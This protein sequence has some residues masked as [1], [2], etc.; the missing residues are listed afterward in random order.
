M[1]GAREESELTGKGEEARMK[2]R[3][4]AELNELVRNYGPE[5]VAQAI[6]K[7]AAARA[8]GADYIAN[9]LRQQSSPRSVEPPVRLKD[10]R[11][12]Q[13]APEQ[14]SLLEYDAFLLIDPEKEAS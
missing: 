7:A 5:T 6:D 4:I 3:Q 12:N 2:A 9:I 11:L 1:T 13:L 8:F 14:L 10:Q